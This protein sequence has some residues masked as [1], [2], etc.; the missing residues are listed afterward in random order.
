MS[1]EQQAYYDQNP[2]ARW[3][4]LAS[5]CLCLF[6]SVLTMSATNIAIPVMA[7]ELQ[8]SAVAVSWIPLMAIWGMVM[9]LLPVGRLADIYGRKKLYVIGLISFSTVS[10]FIFF[11]DSIESLLVLRV[12]Q[13]FSTAMVNGTGVAIIGSIFVNS[14][15]GMALGISASSVYF[16]LSCGPLIGGLIAEYFGWRA[17]FWMPVLVILIALSLVLLNL[18][19]EWKQDKPEPLD[20]LG[21]LLFA[22]WVSCFF[23]GS[24]GLP[25]WKHSLLILAGFVLL[26]VFLRQQK[27]A[28]YPLV[29]LNIL[30]KNRVFSRSI[31]SSFLMYGAHFASIFLLILYLQYIH[32]LTPLE[33]GKLLLVQ[34]LSMMILAPIAG[35]LSDKF[36]PRIIGTIGCALVAVGFV[37]LSS[38]GLETSMTYV[39]ISL[40]FL[41]VGFG[42]FSSPN[43]HATIGAAQKKELSIASALLSLSRTMGNMFGNSLVMMLMSVV[44]GSDTVIQPANYPQLLWIIQTSFIGSI[45]AALVA[46]YFSFSRGKIHCI[47]HL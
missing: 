5:I 47:S 26:L 28:K 9:L 41:G 12:M 40:V 39:F 46:A 14:G 15:R 30:V 13:G 31:L 37:L 16:G 35:R 42:L 29:R 1:A 4:A 34:M 45:F 23:V 38:V 7:K 43:N 21:S 22:A 27:R 25:E 18:K 33:A 6:I 11:V 3:L 19:G 10:L 44:I 8:A 17:I 24:S 36:E 32:D 2:Q 20:K